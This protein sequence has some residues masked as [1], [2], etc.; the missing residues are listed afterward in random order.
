MNFRKSWNYT[1]LALSYVVKVTM[2]ID[3]AVKV[4]S[5]IMS[6]THALHSYSRRCVL[7]IARPAG[8]AV[9]CSSWAVSSQGG[10]DHAMCDHMSF[11][12]LL[13][14]LLFV[15]TWFSISDKKTV[16]SNDWKKSRRL[17]SSQKPLGI[18]RARVSLCLLICIFHKCLRNECCFWITK[19]NYINLW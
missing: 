6:V 1:S 3:R 14:S 8:P 16:W 19:A 4:N 13:P 18:W 11:P 12:T 15:V 9:I 10:C 17:V 7:V 2:K 5:K